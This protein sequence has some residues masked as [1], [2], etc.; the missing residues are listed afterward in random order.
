MRSSSSHPNQ[1]SHQ[2]NRY[3][4]YNI[5][6]NRSQS[7]VHDR[8]LAINNTSRMPYQSQVSGNI[9]Q[10]VPAKHNFEQ[11]G[12]AAKAQLRGFKNLGQT[13]YANTSL[14]FLI[15]TIGQERLFNHL[16]NLTEPKDALNKFI[17]IVLNAP[18][19]DDCLPPFQGEV[20]DTQLQELFIELQKL[21]TFNSFRIIRQQ[22]D[23][24]EFLCKLSALFALDQL[25]SH[26]TYLQSTLINGYQ[27]RKAPQSPDTYLQTAT[28]TKPD[29]TLQEIVE[30]IYPTEQVEVKWKENDLQNTL[31]T[32]RHELVVDLKQINRFNIH[33]AAVDYASAELKKIFFSQANFT[34]Q[35]QVPVIDAQT[36][37]KWQLTLEPQ[38][39]V[40]HRGSTADSGHYYLYTKTGEGWQKHDDENVFTTN[41]QP[42]E[43]AKLISF[44]IVR[45][46]RIS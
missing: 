38:E 18:D 17:Q 25:S 2:L 11:L 14:K 8:L 46:E 29:A 35:I 30:A 5:D 1:V 36:R 22:H 7:S 19:K 37:D 24:S 41:I 20:L 32:K 10:N 3:T 31:V 16:A 33:I 21:P 15:L 34:D 44:A 13:C 42:G 12:T 9:R 39:I 23:P 45:K 43:Q 4:P 28:I 26:S 27:E 40:V 6:K